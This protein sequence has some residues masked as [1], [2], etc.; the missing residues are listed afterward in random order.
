MRGG[1]NQGECAGAKRA[2]LSA[3]EKSRAL[4][5]PLTGMG[6]TGY[7]VR[8][9]VGTLM[10]DTRPALDI[11]G[12]PGVPRGH[13]GVARTTSRTSAATYYDESSFRLRRSSLRRHGSPGEGSI[14]LP[15]TSWLPLAVQQ[16]R[17]E[18]LRSSER[19]NTQAKADDCKFIKGE[20]ES[21]ELVGG[22]LRHLGRDRCLESGWGLRG[23]EQQVVRVL[24]CLNARAKGA[25]AQLQE[26]NQLMEAGSPEKTAA[27]VASRHKP[28]R[29]DHA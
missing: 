28:T 1:E 29:G 10:P 19:A 25:E 16:P 4:P 14:R 9:P 24:D 27:A 8:Y 6:I 22:E 20:L 15:A 7:R 26:M 21:R 13:L 17:D 5:I 2:T 11:S 23:I 3:R 18:Q 12:T